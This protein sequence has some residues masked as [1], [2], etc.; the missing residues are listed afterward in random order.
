MLV[1]LYL[2]AALGWADITAT[3]DVRQPAG[4]GGVT[5]TRGRQNEA[6]TVDPGSASLTINNRSGR[7]SPRNLRSDLYGLI[8][9]NTPIR[10]GDRL[11]ADSFAR[12]AV[13]G[14]WG[15]TPEGLV[16]STGA[17]LSTFPNVAIITHPTINAHRAATLAVDLVDA[18]QLVEVS[19]PA[20]TGAAIVTGLV[21]RYRDPLNFYWLRTER[22]AGG[23][24]VMLKMTKTVAGVEHELAVLNPVP[25]LVAGAGVPIATRASVVGGHLA[26]SAWRVTGGVEPRDWQLETTDTDP[27]LAGAGRVGVNTWVVS[28]NT[29]A[30]PIEVRHYRHQVIDRRFTGE[31]PTWPAQ[32]SLDGNDVYVPIEAAGIMRR[33]NQGAR[34]VR[35][36]L[37][38]AF[39]TASPAPIAWYPLEDGRDVDRAASGLPGQP[40]VAEL[41]R[42]VTPYTSIG[43]ADGSVVWGVEGSGGAASLV[44]LQTGGRLIAPVPR[45]TSDSWT[46]EYVVRYPAKSEL[47]AGSVPMTITAAGG[48]EWS[49]LFSPNG[50]PNQVAAG[51]GG[52]AGAVV[53]WVRDMWDGLLH[54]VRLVVE[55]QG[56]DAA[57]YVYVDGEYIGGAFWLATNPP[58]PDTFQPNAYWDTGSREAAVGEL[59]LFDYADF[60][61]TVRPAATQAWVG[62]HATDRIRRLCAEDGVPIT[63]VDGA[64]PSLAPMG[65]QRIDT[66]LNLLSEAAGVDMGILGEQRAGLGLLYR[67]RTSLENQTPATFDYAAGHISAPFAPVDDDALIRNDVEATRP[68]GGSARS[69]QRTGPLSVQRVGTYEVSVPTPVASDT[70]L[71]DHAG[72]GRH[73]GTWDAAR[74]PRI[75]VNLESRV[76]RAD[77]AL[78]SRA[79]S[80]DAGDRVAVVNLPAWLPAGPADGLVQGYTERFGNRGARSITW[81]AAPAGPWDVATV[82]GAQ[83]VPAD[84]SVLA[85][86]L[87]AAGMSF[88]VTSTASNGPWV[89]SA[90]KPAVFPMPVRVDGEKIMVSSIVGTGLTQTF[91][92]A[93]GGRGANGYARAWPA[94]APVDVWSPAIAAL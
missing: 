59:A 56:A 13:S 60:Y 64:D 91:N 42:A 72:W 8:G 63:V 2:G 35:S 67:T 73:L 84:G 6:S 11:T 26:M 81:N 24:S 85:A 93:A 32:W 49:F 71:P 18:E 16:W 36:P 4:G 86:A 31:V 80:L 45:S 47:G 5:I 21:F 34:P 48:Y 40:P 51:I 54:H 89:T 74:Y 29:N 3:N 27:A 44:G 90:A 66:L 37:Y 30:L 20:A 39:A 15:T 50:G 65:P 46:F 70:Q 78:T 10:I 55:Q 28:G 9:L 79:A 23:T 57:H 69:V 7:Y 12:P 22:I 19:T 25:G 88:S 62:E 17:D 58:T 52:T 68:N 87:T 61:D 94:G 43:V 41:G 53:E 1:E 77:L 82:D 92:V 76:F 75:T 83:R 14:G 38:R 33:L